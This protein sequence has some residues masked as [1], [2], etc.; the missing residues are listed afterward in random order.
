[1]I[2]FTNV[3]FTYTEAAAPTL[4]GVDLVVEE[5]E[6]C[7]VVGQTGSGKST[8]LRAI[9]GLVPHF[10]G[11]HLSGEVLVD[12]RSTREFPRGSWPTW[13]VWSARIRPRVS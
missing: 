4:S 7:L 12:G 9:N 1:M 13:S 5:G 3:T 10:T 2:R 11:G 8:L 6:L